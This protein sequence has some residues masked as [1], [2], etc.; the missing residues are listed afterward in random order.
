MSK[1][2]R[3]ESLSFPHVYYTFKAKDK[4]SN[5]VVEY[6]V[7]DL[8]EDY[9]ERA[10]DLIVTD[11]VPQETFCLCKKISE[12]SISIQAIS[13]F[14][15]VMFKNRLTI[16]CFRNDGS[17]DDLV[18]VNVFQVKSIFDKKDDDFEVIF[19]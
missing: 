3:P 15:R 18:A 17:N 11:F 8:P 5:D 13:D 2:E 9:Y 14:Y 4:N 19:Y 6:R 12:S 16:A 7:Q 10:I 1:F